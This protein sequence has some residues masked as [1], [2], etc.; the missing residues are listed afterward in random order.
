MEYL[1]CTETVINNLICVFLVVGER[2]KALEMCWYVNE[3]RDMTIITIPTPIASTTKAAQ[4]K[5]QSYSLLGLNNHIKPR[6][7]EEI[8]SHLK[9]GN[10]PSMFDR[11]SEFM[12]EL[13]FH[14][15]GRSRI[16]GWEHKQTQIC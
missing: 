11:S 13:V 7:F 4:I 15:L 14:Y 2:V 9:V 12:S 3:A 1:T 6:K 5:V 8:L 10:D 16:V